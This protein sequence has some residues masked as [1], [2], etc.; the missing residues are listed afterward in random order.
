MHKLIRE[1]C[2]GKEEEGWKK[3]TKQFEPEASDL[4][5]TKEKDA[6]ASSEYTN[7]F[8]STTDETS[9]FPSAGQTENL[10]V[11][12]QNSSSLKM[13]P[14]KKSNLFKIKHNAFII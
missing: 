11:N 7:P 9:V 2:L 3:K 5:P 10:D 4:S 13:S 8:P 12:R 14:Q 6:P 1:Y